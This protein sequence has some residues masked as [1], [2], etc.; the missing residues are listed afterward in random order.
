M[1]YCVSSKHVCSNFLASV[2]KTGDFLFLSLSLFF[3]FFFFAVLGFEMGVHLE[4]LHRVLRT[5]CP[6]WANPLILL[7]SAS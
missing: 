3:F 1:E 2:R 5:I 4:P 6:G 7:I